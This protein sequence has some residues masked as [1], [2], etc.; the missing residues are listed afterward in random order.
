MVL[1]T[2]VVT[3]VLLG[4]RAITSVRYAFSDAVDYTPMDGFSQIGIQNGYTVYENNYFIPM[5]FSYD[6]AVT[7]EQTEQIS[8]PNKD[9][10]LVRAM[11]L[12]EEDYRSVSDILPLLTDD[13][14]A[15]GDFSSDAYY[16]N[17][18]N[19]AASAV[20]SFSY[21]AKGFTAQTSY[22]NDRVVFFSV[23]YDKGWNASVNGEDAQ[24]L[25]ADAGFMAVRVPSG[26]SEIVFTYQTP[27]LFVGILITIFGI[28]LFA[29]YL[30]A[31]F[32]LRKHGKLPK[33][34]RSIHRCQPQFAPTI[35]A[36][37][38]YIRYCT[39]KNHL[40]PTS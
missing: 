1:S 36:K 38:A 31:V 20:D 2:M 28:F 10:L 18:K 27:G 9:L 15:N 32:F 16:E 17:C 14:I 7:E 5:G 24:I 37:E 33:S 25:K 4:V 29:G 19:R 40:P 35:P 6:A 39:Q 26:K 34:H 23:P 30:W 3:T 13:D 8:C 11:L 22:E 12:S 21:S